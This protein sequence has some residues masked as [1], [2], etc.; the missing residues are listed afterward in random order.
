MKE[1]NV[2]SFFDKYAHDFNAIYGNSNSWFDNIINKLFR[3]S[4]ELRYQKTLEGCSQITGASVLDI[5][6][7]P[8]HYSVALA[9]MGANEVLGIDFA[10]G[11]LQVAHERAVKEGVGSVCKFEKMN[12]ITEDF[13]RKFDY[14][15]LMGL[16]DYMGHP[17]EIVKKALA[18]THIRAFFSFPLDDGFLAWQRK[19]RYQ[20]RCD[21]Y[22]YTEEQ[23]R[24]MFEKLDYTNLS[25][26]RIDRDLMV[27]VDMK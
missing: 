16:M 17:L 27:I 2:S 20:S 15:V 8:G 26:E 10:D 4:M 18:I 9:K 5:G 13:D 25:I 12:F 6:C 1:S 3:R 14:V 24:E 11:M 22:L 19:L 7:G 23:I 21:L